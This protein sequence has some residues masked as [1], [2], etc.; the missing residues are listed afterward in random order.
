MLGI[1]LEGSREQLLGFLLVAEIDLVELAG[2]EEQARLLQ[3]V[4][5]TGFGAHHH[6]RGLERIAPPLV[7]IDERQHA[8]HVRRIDAE[9]VGQPL[10]GRLRHLHVLV[11]DLAQAE[12]E[13][14]LL[15]GLDHI[16][17]PLHDLDRAIPLLGLLVDARETLERFRMIGIEAKDVVVGLG[18]SIGIAQLL[19]EKMTQRQ[20][21]GGPLRSLGFDLDV[22]AVDVD[23]GV[24][25]AIGTEQ[26][27]DVAVDAELLIVDFE[28]VQQALDG[29]FGLAWLLLPNLCH[30]Q[31]QA[32]PFGVGG[33]YFQLVLEDL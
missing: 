21:D 6:L 12:A 4:L 17:E 22:P 23:Q 24:P 2:L 3:H 9:C 19:L 5:R 14:D 26:A 20:L 13:V 33:G 15:I 18:C 30:A 32:H 16:H 27:L 1:E 31:V 28:H 29:L 7:Q 8:W 11:E 25:V 10:L